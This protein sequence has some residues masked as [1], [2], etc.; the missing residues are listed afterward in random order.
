MATPVAE[1]TAAP[2]LGIGESVEES[3][4]PSSSPSMT[5]TS[6][7]PSRIIEDSPIPSAALTQSPYDDIEM[8]DVIVVGV[9]DGDSFATDAGGTSSPT[10]ATGTPSHGPSTSATVTSSNI[11]ANR[12]VGNGSAPT[13]AL[14]APSA[15]PLIVNEAGTPDGSG[16]E[17]G[18]GSIQ[19]NGVATVR[20][21][22]DLLHSAAISYSPSVSTDKVILDVEMAIGE[23]LN[24]LIV[25]HESTMGILAQYNV[26]IDSVQ[27]E[28]KVDST[29]LSSTLTDA[30]TVT[31]SFDEGISEGQVKFILS[32]HLERVVNDLRSDYAIDDFGPRVAMADAGFMILGVDQLPSEEDIS[33]FEDVVG[34]YLNEEL[35]ADLTPRR[36][37]RGG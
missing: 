36:R 1:G 26:A 28:E 11:E 21:S 23:S 34:D 3:N 9:S 16:T 6:E 32:E 12:E 29:C 7:E 22:I 14:D 13:L 4:K 33:A 37:R 18:G 5:S 35:G 25:D 31:A 27:V 10:I 20:Q 24:Q 8:D 15:S 19:G 17:S 2:S 30:I